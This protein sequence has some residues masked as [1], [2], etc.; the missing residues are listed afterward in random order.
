MS[1]DVHDSEFPPPPTADDPAAPT[2]PDSGGSGGSFAFILIALLVLAGGVVYVLGASAR[3]DEE[4]EVAEASARATIEA[5]DPNEFTSELEPDELALADDDEAPT[6]TNAPATTA[7]PDG[8]DAVADDGA[9]TPPTTSPEGIEVGEPIDPRDIALAF[10]NRIPGEEYETVGW[11]DNDGVRHTT[12]LECTRLDL[13]EA[14]GICLASDGGLGGSARGFI[15]DAALVPQNSFGLNRPSRAAVSPDGAVVVW[16]GFTLGHSYLAEGEF[17]TITQL[18]SVERSLGANLET[19]FL[20]IDDGVRIENP[21]RNYWGVTFVDSDHFY[22]TMGTEGT[23]SIV[24]G[25]ISNSTIEV[26]YENASCPEVSPDGSTIVAKEL[27]GDRFQLVAIDVASGERRD[28]GETMMVD[29]QVEFLDD[30]TIL[31]AKI[32]EAEGTA[33]QPV[34]D[35]WA[36]DLAP[37]STPRMVVPFADSPAA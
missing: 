18:I 34:F 36:L 10:V 6:A 15:L 31:Y 2:P 22:A 12:G 17:A 27:R 33:A 3:A 20:T 29:D 25:R 4:T 14:G 30:D 32:N 28:L 35:I 23:T 37:G 24:E 7:A 5:F 21:D 11:I 19:D 13:N 8:D 1:D 9:T 16:T 26:R